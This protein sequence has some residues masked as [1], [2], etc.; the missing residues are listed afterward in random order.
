VKVRTHHADPDQVS[1]AD[2]D[3]KGAGKTVA[4][5]RVESSVRYTQKCSVV[6][7][8]LSN[9]RNHVLFIPMG[10]TGFEPLPVPA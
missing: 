4:P 7:Q 5:I 6:A 10:D 9:W 1:V 3:G 8:V 2:T